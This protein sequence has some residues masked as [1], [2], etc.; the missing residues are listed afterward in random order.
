MQVRFNTLWKVPVFCA[1]ASWLSFYATVYLGGHFFT[2][3]TIGDDCSKILSADPVRSAIF[4]GTLFVLVLLAGGLWAFRSMTR[5][6]I[7]VSAGIAAGI[8]LLI[9]LAQLYITGFPLSASVWL[10]KFQ[11]WT[12]TASSLLFKITGNLQISALLS[13]LC[14]LLFIP[15]GKSN[16]TDG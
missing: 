2:V 6:E 8:Y 1:I 4:N 14:P 7:A 3:V 9:V 13:T 12:S 11:N 5:K 10:A 16:I 15:F